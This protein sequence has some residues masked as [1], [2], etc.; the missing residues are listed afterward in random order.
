MIPAVYLSL[1]IINNLCS[2]KVY[3]NNVKYERLHQGLLHWQERHRCAG[4]PV[5]PTKGQNGAVRKI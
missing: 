1:A 5:V 3:Q 4:R 2:R